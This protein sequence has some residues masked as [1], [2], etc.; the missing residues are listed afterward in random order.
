M[1]RPLRIEFEN[2]IYH[3]CARG[4]AR[5]R[6]FQTEADRVHFLKLLEQS[7]ARFDVALFGFV[8]MSNHY[9][10]IA[11]TRRANLS[12][13]VHW[14]SVAYTVYFN[15]RHNRS[16]HLFQGRF[17]SFLVEGK[18]EYLL[19][20]SRYLHL[21]PVRGVSLGRGNPQERRERL[22]G[23][24]WSSY[25]GYAGLEPVLP[26]V[27][28]GPVFEAFGP[29]AKSRRIGYRRFVEEGLLREVKNPFEMVRWQAVLGSETFVQKI[30][31]RI[32][33]RE[34]EKREV[35]GIR[36]S[37]RNIETEEICRRV[38]KKYRVRVSD[39]LEMERRGCEARSVAMWMVWESGAKSLREIGQDFGGLDYAAVAQRIR[40]TRARTPLKDR[41]KLVREMLNV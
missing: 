34:V 28:E 36:Q 19:T 40:R 41:D 5:E 21:N 17:K 37:S 15:R 27:E 16:G 12:R 14:L 38:A 20:L 11:Q 4:N 1:A 24:K 8:L 6:V 10:L 18:S 32:A 35:T 29:P 3:V 9:H 2:A 22:R 13:W 23:F 30:R 26:F 7:L 31:D 39:V 33:S 25:R